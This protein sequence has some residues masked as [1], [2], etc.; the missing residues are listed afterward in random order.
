M[1]ENGEM[2]EKDKEKF[3]LRQYFLKSIEELGV[4]I[5]IQKQEVIPCL[6][7]NAN[8]TMNISSYCTL[9]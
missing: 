4:E 3:E 1:G 7:S 9:G 5:E 8:S 6:Y 2:S